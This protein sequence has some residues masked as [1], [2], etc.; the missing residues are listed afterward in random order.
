MSF[1]KNFIIENGEM[2]AELIGFIVITT[3]AL[4]W[5]DF[6]FGYQSKWRE[7]NKFKEWL[8]KI[9]KW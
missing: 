5:Y 9:L 6:N 1:T 2:L 3:L 7:K 4:A 8:F